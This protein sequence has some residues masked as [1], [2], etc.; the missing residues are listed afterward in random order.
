MS[1]RET[2]ERLRSD[3]VPSGEESAKFKIIAPLLAELGWDPGGS[4]V[5][6]EETVGGKGS[7]RVDIALVGPDRMVALIEAKR[8]GA[9]LRQHVSQVLGYAFHDG[10]DICVLTTGVEWWLYLPREGGRPPQRRFARLHIHQDPADQL[11]EDLESFLGRANLLSGR[12]QRQAK[13]VLKAKRDADRLKADI[14]VVWRRMLDQPDEDLLDLVARRVYEQTDLRPSRPQV[15]AVFR[16]LPIPSAP[17]EPTGP[18]PQ[19]SSARPT[20]STRETPDALVL[21]ERREDATGMRARAF[22]LWGDRY[23]VRNW[24]DLLA[25]MAALL[26]KRHGAAFEKIFDLKLGRNTVPVITREPGLLRTPRQVEDSGIYL[27][28]R[29][30][31]RSGFVR[32]HAFLDCFGH[33]ETD[34]RIWA[35][36]ASSPSVGTPAASRPA[37]FHLWDNTYPFRTWKACLVQVVADLY[38]RHSHDFERILGLRGRT[39][40]LAALEPAELIRAARVGESPIYIETNLSGKDCVRRARLFLEHFGH[41]PTDLK[42]AT[43]TGSNAG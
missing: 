12:A 4:H 8:P 23:E 41:P 25:Q 11:S 26:Q 42:F 10:V 39:R 18:P 3:P 36:Q 38:L 27:N 14:P 19:P 7:G 35:E 31:A 24:P 20:G 17:P 21:I 5:R 29:F 30:T 15:A 28:A 32:A 40:P 16:G 9:D 22:E 6:Y 43:E 2:I 37:W 1:L 13:R 33:P 34:L